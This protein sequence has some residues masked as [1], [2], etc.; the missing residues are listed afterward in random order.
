VVELKP[1]VQ[2]PVRRITQA[3]I[4]WLDAHRVGLKGASEDAVTTVMRIR[5]EDWR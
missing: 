2:Q 3:D 4:D 1:V 5:D